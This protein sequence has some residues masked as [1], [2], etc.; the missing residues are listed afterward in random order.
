MIEQVK[1]IWSELGLTIVF[2]EHDMDIV[3]ATAQ[4]I[5]VLVSGAVLASGAPDDVR[6]N[7]RVIDAYLGSTLEE[8]AAT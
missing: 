5:H 3:F 7:P 8:E 2:I 6:S 1:S 4:K